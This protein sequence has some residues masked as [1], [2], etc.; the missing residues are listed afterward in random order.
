[1]TIDLDAIE[2]AARAATPGPWLVRS[3]DGEAWPE[4]RMSV[5]PDYG[6][7]AEA[8]A[9]SPR[10]AGNTSNNFFHIARM[11][12]ETTLALVKE[13]RRLQKREQ[14]LLQ[15]LTRHERDVQRAFCEEAERGQRIFRDVCLRIQHRASGRPEG[16]A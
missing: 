14:K 4:K 9:I 11:D 6:R 1:M 13:V 10:Y 16:A 12:P 5:G 7:V 2:A 15:D 3:F 8:V